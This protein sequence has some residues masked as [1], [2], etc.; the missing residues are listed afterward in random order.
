MKKNLILYIITAGNVILFLIPNKPL[1]MLIVELILA[2]FGIILAK[3]T[4]KI[5]LKIVNMIFFLWSALGILSGFIVLIG[6]N[7]IS[8]EIQN[9]WG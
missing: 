4:N 6:W 1:L 2:L 5:I 7:S 8:G 3:K 9:V